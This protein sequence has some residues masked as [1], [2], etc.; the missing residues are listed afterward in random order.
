MEYNFRPNKDKLVYLQLGVIKDLDF[1]ELHRGPG[2][3]LKHHPVYNPAFDTPTTY[4]LFL[5][6]SEKLSSPR[7]GRVEAK[8]EFL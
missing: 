4:S 5:E 1:L 3:S 6:A 8:L 7:N 2:P